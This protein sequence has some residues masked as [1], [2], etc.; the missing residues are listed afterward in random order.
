MTAAALGDADAQ[1]G[2]LQGQLGCE[3]RRVGKG[4]ALPLKKDSSHTDQGAAGGA[5]WKH[6]QCF[7]FLLSKPCPLRL[8]NGNF[9][10]LIGKQREASRKFLFSSLHQR[11]VWVSWWEGHL[12]FCPI[13]CSWSAKRILHL[14]LYISSFKGRKSLMEIKK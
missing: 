9:P 11:V 2:M 7:Y 1:W 5:L 6:T 14:L 13:V 12:G 8:Q 3:A 10:R 4:W